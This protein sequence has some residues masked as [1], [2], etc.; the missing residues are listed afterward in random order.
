MET[1]CLFI[2]L[3]RV[4]HGPSSLPQTV[5]LRFISILFFRLRLLFQVNFINEIFHENVTRS[6]I[7]VLF[8]F[9]TKLKF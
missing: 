5:S 3:A 4:R 2:A 7:F 8:C 6:R 9:D 1:D